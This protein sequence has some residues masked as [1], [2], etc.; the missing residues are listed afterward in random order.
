MNVA[1]VC[2]LCLQLGA[3]A[4]QLLDDEEAALTPKL[5]S[6]GADFIADWI[7][8]NIIPHLMSNLKKTPAYSASQCQ[9]RFLQA[10]P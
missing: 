1:K 9:L 8:L 4:P 10:H 3:D 6:E 5:E 7:L 2:Q